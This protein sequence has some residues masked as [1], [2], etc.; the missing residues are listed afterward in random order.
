MSLRVLKQ[1]E[2]NQTL[3]ALYVIV[4]RGRNTQKGTT[5]NSLRQLVGV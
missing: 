5:E 4:E 3:T 2:V 1:K